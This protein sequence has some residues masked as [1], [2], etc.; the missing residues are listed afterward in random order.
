MFK[1]LKTGSALLK[2]SIKVLGKHPIFIVP[3]FVSWW[4]YIQKVCKL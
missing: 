1:G 3:L 2:Q 4:S